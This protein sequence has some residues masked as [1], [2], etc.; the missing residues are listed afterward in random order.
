MLIGCPSSN[1]FVV[2][3]SLKAELNRRQEDSTALRKSRAKSE[4]RS[5]KTKGSPQDSW[6]RRLASWGFHRFLQAYS[7]NT[8]STL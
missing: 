4:P 7:T 8:D 2:R 1:V 3:R 5:D 6:E